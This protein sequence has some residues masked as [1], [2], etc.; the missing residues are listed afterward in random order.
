M[1]MGFALAMW[2]KLESAGARMSDMEQLA[3]RSSTLEEYYDLDEVRIELLDG[4]IGDSDMR[5]KLLRALIVN[6]G[7]I[8]TVRLAPPQVWR[9]ALRKSDGHR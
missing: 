4:Y 3:G 2:W 9:E 8:S 5:I 6:E 7:L 1:A